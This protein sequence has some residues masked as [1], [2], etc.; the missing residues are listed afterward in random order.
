MADTL[1]IFNAPGWID[2]TS[3]FGPP[4]GPS[5][6]FVLLFTDFSSVVTGVRAARPKELVRLMAVVQADY[7]RCAQP[8]PPWGP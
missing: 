4:D 2:T 8:S 6:F 1:L 5:P 3:A 7:P